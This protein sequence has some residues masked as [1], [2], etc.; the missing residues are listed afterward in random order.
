MA[1]RRFFVPSCSRHCGAELYGRDTNTLD[2]PVPFAA[3]D[4]MARDPEDRLQF[5]Y[6]IIEV[7]PPPPLQPQAR[8]PGTALPELSCL[9]PVQ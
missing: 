4:V 5:H 3:A 2:S 8:C 1:G 7:P 6:A 9:S